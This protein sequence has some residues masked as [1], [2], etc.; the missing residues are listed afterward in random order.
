[1]TRK[2]NDNEFLHLREY[3]EKH[4][5]I[6]LNTSQKYL[7]ET[8]LDNL[9]YEY[10][11]NSFA[12][13]YELAQKN[14]ESAL[15]EKIINA[16]TT[17]ETFWFRDIHPWKAFSEHLLPK[18]DKRN[19]T[20]VRIW[21]AAASTGQEAYSMAMLSKNYQ[22]RHP[23]SNIHQQIEI[24]GTDISTSAL[25]VAISGCYNE[26]SMNRGFVQPWTKYKTAYFKQQGRVWEIAPEI[27]KVVRFLP[28]N[29]QNSFKD[30]DK[31]DL[32][33]LRNVII[34]FSDDLKKSLFQKLASS[35]REGGYL[36]IGASETPLRY[37]NQFSLKKLNNSTFYQLK[38]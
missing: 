30:L 23:A 33:C 28:F 10:N 17:N 22:T 13:L 24:T 5:G 19:T 21:S 36:L 15:R 25:Y 26:A 27:K 34:Y 7:L 32:I 6:T 8:R 3:I 1:M 11:F 31:F 16:M 12:Q 18:W 35:L 9:L 37:S 38:D 4:C 29:L 2:L 14:P 20:P